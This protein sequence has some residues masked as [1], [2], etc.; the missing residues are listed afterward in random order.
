MNTDIK[1]LREKTIV[2]I[3]KDEINETEVNQHKLHLL[4]YK[5]S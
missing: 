1:I 3:E 4:W 5:K 2:D